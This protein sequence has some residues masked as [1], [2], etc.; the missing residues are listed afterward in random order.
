M[1]KLSFIIF[2]FL[3][4]IQIFSQTIITETTKIDANGLKSIVTD[5]K[6]KPVLL[7][8]WATWC[9][10][11][12]A[13]FPDLVKINA[14]F[15]NKNLVFNVISVDDSNLIDT[16]IADFLKEYKSTMPSFL[17]DSPT[18]RETAKII[19]QFALQFRDIY[20]LTLLF[21]KKGK[22]TYQKIGKIDVK[23]LRKEISKVL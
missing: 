18:R 7:N 12:R 15:A 19:R 6:G 3:F 13:E 17:I 5:N 9:S 16:K 10:P 23:I 22:L 4:S 14:D 8:F 1:K 11:C 21:D 2:T 20:P